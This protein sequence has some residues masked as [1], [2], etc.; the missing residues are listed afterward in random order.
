MDRLGA[1]LQRW[2]ERALSCQEPTREADHN[3]HVYVGGIET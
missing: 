3:Y 1:P 2:Q